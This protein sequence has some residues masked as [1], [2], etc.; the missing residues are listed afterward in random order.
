MH[1]CVSIWLEKV[2]GPKIYIELVATIYGDL[3]ECIASFP[4]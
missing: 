1:T 2:P 3:G 4:G